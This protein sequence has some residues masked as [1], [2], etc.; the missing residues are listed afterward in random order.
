MAKIYAPNKRYT[1]LIA[2]VS[3]VDGAGETEDKYLINWFEEKG[4]KTVEEKTEAPLQNGEKLIGDIEEAHDIAIKE[5]YIKSLEELKV[6]ELKELA[7]EK[8]IKGYSKMNKEELIAALAG[9]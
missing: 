2:G 3:F 9:D 6:E 4:Y 1:G 7:K 5:N 8:E